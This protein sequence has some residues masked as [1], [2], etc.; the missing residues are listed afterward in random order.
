MVHYFHFT[1]VFSVFSKTMSDLEYSILSE[2]FKWI[3]THHNIQVDLI[4]RYKH[5]ATFGYIHSY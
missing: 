3:T 4:G 2:W 5:L 1:C